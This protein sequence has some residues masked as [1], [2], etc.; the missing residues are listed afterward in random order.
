MRTTSR[1]R[2]RLWPVWTSVGLTLAL[3]L[4]S[5]WAAA[6]WFDD[7]FKYPAKAAALTAAVLMCWS[8]VLSARLRL[9]EDFFG[10]LDKVYQVHK[11]LGRRAFWI[12]LLHPLF[13]GADRLPNLPAF[14]GDMWYAAASGDRYL[15][16]QNAGAAALLAMGLLVALS[17][18][19]KPAYDVW[20][21]THEWFGLVVLL[22]AVHVWL[23]DADVA[24]YPLLGVW[25]WGWLAAA[26]GSFVWIRFLYFRLG[27]RHVFRVERVERSGDVLEATL[28]PVSRPMDYKPSQFVYLVVDKPGISPEPHPY[29]IASGYNLQGAVKLGIKQAGD[30][31]RTLSALERGDTALLYGPYGRFSDR[32]LAA[33]RNCVF[34]GGGIGITPF[35]GMWHVALHSEERLDPE[36]APGRLRAMHP[37]MIRTWKSP[38]VALF[39]VV[40]SRDDASFDNT[41]S[42]KYPLARGLYIYLLKDPKKPIDMLSGEFVKYV[43]S[44]DGQLQAK[45]GGYYP[46][47]R[48]IREHELTRLGLLVSAR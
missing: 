16:G 29:S 21:R 10:G 38:L 5:K 40:R 9:L 18:W 24:A 30:H 39:Y 17:L 3:W 48:N 20:K 33:E 32:F 15:W 25:V 7:P 37:E 26:A 42:R 34:I 36:H 22:A 41:Y 2:Q 13:L 1:T 4:G 11:R 23:V 19:I 14:L 27:P 28:A 47:T 45:K 6:D 46:I 44:R 35:L 43:L 8:V 12:I 31:T